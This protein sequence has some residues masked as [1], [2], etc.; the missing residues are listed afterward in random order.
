VSASCID[1]TGYLEMYVPLVGSDEATLQAFAP[2]SMAGLCH[3]VRHKSQERLVEWN[4]S[5]AGI[6]CCQNNGIHRQAMA[7]GS[8]GGASQLSAGPS[9]ADPKSPKQDPLIAV[10][11]FASWPS[12]GLADSLQV[13]AVRCCNFPR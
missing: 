5:G 4:A 13:E 11:K 6:F 9:A 1:A 12:D 10:T 3:K 8:C 2:A 7:E